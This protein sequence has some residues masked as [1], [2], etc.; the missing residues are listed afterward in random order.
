[1]F[2]QQ[3]NENDVM[4]FEGFGK[5]GMGK[6]GDGVLGSWGNGDV[7]PKLVK[8]RSPGFYSRTLKFC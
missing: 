2:H 6:W 3:K 7:A 8:I 1:M 5:G 4:I